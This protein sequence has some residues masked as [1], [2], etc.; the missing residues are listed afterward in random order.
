VVK[1]LKRFYD[2]K[3]YAQCLDNAARALK[4][5]LPC[6]TCLKYEPTEL[7]NTPAEIEGAVNLWRAVFWNSGDILGG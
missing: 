5:S 2:C 7:V 4:P 6:M 3:F 1:R